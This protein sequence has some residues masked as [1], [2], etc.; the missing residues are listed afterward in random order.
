MPF[1][2]AAKLLAA[3]TISST[4]DSG[5][6]SPIRYVHLSAPEKGNRA[7]TL[8]HR[9]TVDGGDDQADLPVALQAGLDR[10]RQTAAGLIERFVILAKAAP[11]RDADEDRDRRHD[12]MGWFAGFG[13]NLG[14]RRPTAIPASAHNRPCTTSDR[15]ANSAAISAGTLLS[16]AWGCGGADDMRRQQHDDRNQP[17]DK[18][19]RSAGTPTRRRPW[20]RR[21]RSTRP[22]GRSI[23]RRRCPAARGQG[24]P[25]VR[26]R[27]ATKPAIAQASARRSS[28]GVA[29]EDHAGQQQERHAHRRRD[30]GDAG[31]EKTAAGRRRVF[32]PWSCAAW[33]CSLG[34]P[35]AGGAADGASCFS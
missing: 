19:F 6:R 18:T 28:I 10:V 29:G 33:S 34:A 32:Q 17:R 9:Q 2:D 21:W 30:G 1:S 11:A 13:A 20:R 26:G 27:V 5:S 23:P 31:V 24:R 16:K 15:A 7:W 35:A 25:R 3:A 4:C 14:Q 12:G 22:G 8:A